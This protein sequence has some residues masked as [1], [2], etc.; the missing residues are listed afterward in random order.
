MGGVLIF[1]IFNLCKQL[2]WRQTFYQVEVLNASLHTYLI[3]AF[4]D[5]LLQIIPQFDF[6]EHRYMILRYFITI[7][8]SKKT[9]TCFN[10]GYHL[11][12]FLY[13]IYQREI[14]FPISMLKFTLLFLEHRTAEIKYLSFLFL[15]RLR[16]ILVS[17]HHILINIL[18]H[19]FNLVTFNKRLIFPFSDV[20][21][22]GCN[23]LIVGRGVKGPLSIIFFFDYCK[24]FLQNSR[25]YF[26]WFFNQVSCNL[27]C[28]LNKLIIHE[29]RSSCVT[30]SAA[31]YNKYK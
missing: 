31:H 2:L 1:C 30:T 18:K 20:F 4:I 8:T 11:G 15:I 16:S 13:F 23:S 9:F 14:T 6:L 17:G 3:L 21:S 24:L 22:Q 26:P 10:V 7:F 12:T 28:T 27:S 19:A 25:F 5:Q 29:W